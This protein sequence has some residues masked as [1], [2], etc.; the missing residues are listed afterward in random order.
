[1]DV[2]VNTRIEARNAARELQ[3][4]GFGLY[5]SKPIGTKEG[6]EFTYVHSNDGR[7]ATILFIQE[8]GLGAEFVI[9]KFAPR[10]VP[11]WQ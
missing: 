10:H 2:I 9:A 4:S 1:M 7:I 6:Y 11:L 3:E 5:D 8:D